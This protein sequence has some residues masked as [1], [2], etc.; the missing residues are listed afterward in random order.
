MANVI[1][2]DEEDAG[3]ILAAEECPPDKFLQY[4]IFSKHDDTIIRKL[5]AH[6]PVLIRGGRGSG[7]SALL[8]EAHRRMK[9]AGSTF[10]VYMSLRY[11]PLLQSDGAEYVGH[12]CGLL[13]KAIAQEISARGLKADFQH[14]ENEVDL[15][16][17]LNS[18]S[19]ALGLRVVI[20]FDDAA[21]IGREKPLE[22]FFDLFRTLSSASVSCKAS[23]Y[24]GV[25]KFGV[26]FDVYNDSTVIDISRVG[27]VTGA[28]YFYEI[29]KIRYPV[30]ANE[31]IFSESID[32]EK[33]SEIIGRS[34]V[35]NMR[36]FILACNRFDNKEK[37]S[38]PDINA[39]LLAMASDYYWPLME[40][41]APKLGVYEPLIPVAQ[42]VF[43]NIVSHNVRNDETSNH[44]VNDKTTIHS[45]VV[46]KYSKAF[47][48]LEYLGFLSK[49]QASR[50]MKSG[51]RGPVF[52]INFCSLLEK[53]PSSRL[54]QGM[55]SRWLSS[56]SD[57]SEIHSSS[58]VFEGIQMPELKESGK[59]GILS[60]NIDVLQK[61]KA[62]PYGLTNDKIE[63]L[64]SISIM[65]VEDILKSDDESILSLDRVGPITLQ[66]IRDV[67]YQAVWM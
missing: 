8:I 19:V 42:F 43:E 38:I 6:G 59:L 45:S 62:Y 12:F 3:L 55:I 49:L 16:H 31:V 4:H 67:S 63:K 1:V 28:S 29:L 50:G 46:S 35:G 57:I 64:K 33:F 61:S 39:C 58:G 32:A 41:V 23:I 51:G 7:K 37:I 14:C 21:H 44:V 40:E 25:T 52:A 53:M 60:K 11:L 20:L 34:V 10:S 36:A 17:G 24:P 22:A 65:T 5:S 56:S 48:I 9:A 15:Q 26:R 30:I 2:A 54:T 47:E 13:S 27:G 66:R 18:L